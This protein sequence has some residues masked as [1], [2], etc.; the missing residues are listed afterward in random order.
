VPNR[1]DMMN[2]SLKPNLHNKKSDLC[3]AAIR[4]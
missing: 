3:N 2:L 1:Q 4:A